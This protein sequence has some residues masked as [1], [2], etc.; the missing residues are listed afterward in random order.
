MNVTQQD[1]EHRPST[2]ALALRTGGS[3]AA[4]VP[5]NFDE[6]F[7][8]ARALAASGEMVPE[9]YRG[10]P[11]K[12]VACLLRGMEVGLT[13]M[14]SLASLAVINGRA[15]L[16]G[17][18]IPALLIKAGH[19]IDV[20]IEGEGDAMKAVATLTRADGRKIVRSFSVDDAKRAG[21][22]QTEAK[23]TR[24]T[25]DGKPYT[26]ENDSPWWR[27]PQRMLSMR[28]RS[29]A[30][31]DGASDALMGL[32]VAEEEIDHLGPDH[33]R[34]IT[35]REEPR[36]GFA[37]VAQQ[38]RGK[39]AERN[40]MRDVAREAMPTESDGEAAYT[41]DSDS[42]DEEAGEDESLDSGE[43]PQEDDGN[44]PD[45]EDAE[46][47]SGDDSDDAEPDDATKVLDRFAAEAEAE[48]AAGKFS[49]ESAAYKQGRR[50]AEDGAPR[51]L[52]PHAKGP[53][54]VDWLAG[55]DSAAE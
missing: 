31:R 7:R 6:T 19:S 47:V 2:S 50:E 24:K 12:V 43:T 49:R 20:E 8:L 45:I 40:A 46:E 32:R 9:I 23:V 53:R 11:E 42:G 14:Q 21:L 37:A 17:D 26:K 33:A 13:P 41:A 10:E 51:D 39:I 3:L 36:T 15:C 29:W 28:A 18:A 35:P 38:A 1:D 48:L 4:I 5:Q 30:A 54:R 52:C 25:R 44:A 22:W 55:W 34:D 27:Y 16:W